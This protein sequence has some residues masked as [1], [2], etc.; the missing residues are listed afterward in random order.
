MMEQDEKVG[1][2]CR[3]F[4]NLETDMKIYSV[5][6]ALIV[7]L[8][9]GLDA[10]G[11]SAGTGRPS[12]AFYTG[13]YPNLFHEHLGVS[14]DETDEKLARIWNHFFVDDETKVY[15]EDSDST[16]YI[17]DT[18][19]NDVRT[20]GMS[21][22]M[23]I[24]VQMD[25]RQEFD[26]IWRWTKKYMHYT[27]GRWSGYFAWQ[28][29]TDGKKIGEEPSCATDGEI[30]FIT[31]LFFAS[32][33]WGNEGAYNYEKEAQQIL[34]DVMSKDGTGDIYNM[35]DAGS[36]LV[37]FVPS[38][39]MRHFT[40]PSYNL[41]AFFELWA[42][43]ADSDQDFWAQTPDAARRLLVQASHPVT[44]LFPDYSTFDGK[45][46]QPYWKEDYD[47]RRYQYDAIRCAMNVGMD[48]YWFG[49][50]ASRQTEMMTRLLTF[51]KNDNY[52][53]GQFELDGKKPTGSYSEG[54][55]GANAVG[56]FALTDKE[57]AREYI[58]RLWNTPL[59]T[60]KFR[61]YAGMVYML[62]MLH[63]SGNF[64]VY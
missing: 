46:H 12:G 2:R 14:Q 60:G 63:V 54:M 58:L 24:C 5:F 53:H 38:R 31:S 49:K 29:T 1:K 13:I 9:C 33:R 26:K 20:E 25:K 50:D 19:S 39:D 15:Y 16:A 8:G 55:A 30:Y 27:L 3:T 45:P 18:G 56:A 48:Y 37:T 44:G 11:K 6:L 61:Y 4:D 7:C 43:W 41:P 57:L 23:M 36:K 22:G 21:Y 40:D 42:L 35:F 64:R 32:H 34:K 28:C 51:L 52:T 17:Y 47:A 10:W 62:S 59:P